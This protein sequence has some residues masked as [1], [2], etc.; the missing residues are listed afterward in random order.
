MNQ[1]EGILTL[2]LDTSPVPVG[3]WSTD[4]RALGSRARFEPG[5]LTALGALGRKFSSLTTDR[6]CVQPRWSNAN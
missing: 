1:S 4:Q 3:A 2:V 6:N 5:N